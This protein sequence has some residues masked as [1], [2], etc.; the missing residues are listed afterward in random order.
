MTAT[1]RYSYL[2]LL[3][4]IVLAGWFGL[5]TPLITVLFSFFVLDRLRVLQRKWLTV[6]SFLG[7]VTVLCLGLAYFIDQAIRTLPDVATT[8]IPQIIEY[9]RNHNLQL[10]FSDWDSLKSF[11]VENIKGELKYVGTFA[12]SATKQF[13]FLVI[14]IVIATSLFLRCSATTGITRARPGDD[15]ASLMAWEIAARFRSLYDCFNRVMGAQLL[16]SGIN[17]LLT[18]LFVVW[19]GMPYP[20]LLIVITFL[21]GILPIIGNLISN[22]II[23]IVAFTVTPQMAVWALVFLVVLHKLEYFLNSKIIG[24]RI[25]NPVWLT[26]IGL[27]IGERLMGVTGMILAPIILNFLRV[28]AAQIRVAMER[29][30]NR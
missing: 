4:T 30:A 22:S 6:A 10:P 17:T 26:L 25:N 28:E 9:A 14:G 13:V 3:G 21:C 24:D 18:A 29:D 19:S 16:I 15:L 27:V 7:L 8:T 12:K 2:V 20:G 11:A 1:K 23:V 5:G